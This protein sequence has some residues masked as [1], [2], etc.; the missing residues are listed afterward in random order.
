MFVRYRTVIWDS[1]LHCMRQFEY[2]IHF[3]KHFSKATEKHLESSSHLST[4]LKQVKFDPKFISN[5]IIDNDTWVYGYDTE[6]KE[7]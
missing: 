1:S 7:Q 3:C 5:F 4:E 2:E 6:A